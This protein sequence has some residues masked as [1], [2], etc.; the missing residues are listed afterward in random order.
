[1]FD[2][3]RSQLAIP[4]SAPSSRRALLAAS[5]GSGVAFVASALGRPSS[6]LAGSDGDVVL[7]SSVNVTSA[8]TKITTT[9]SVTTFVAENNGTGGIAISAMATELGGSGLYAEAQS[10]DGVGVFGASTDGTG[11]AAQSTNG[12]AVRGVSASSVGV[13]GLTSSSSSYAVWG[14]ATGGIGVLGQSGSSIGV[15]GTSTSWIGVAGSSGSTFAVYGEAN[16]SGAGAIGVHGTSQNGV[17]M[18]GKSRAAA[19]PGVIGWSGANSTG[20]QGIS[21]AN[22]AN[23]PTPKAKTGVFGQA[24]QD[25][26]SRGVF[27]VSTSGNGVRGESTTGGAVVG[28][29]NNTA[30]YAFLGSGRVRFNKVSGLATIA[31]GATSVTVT[32]G[33]D[34]TSESFVLLTAKTNIGT[35]SLYFTT[36]P[37][38]NRF[39]IRLSASPSVSTVV[40]WLLLG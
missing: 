9:T 11:V 22:E 16:G 17:G 34:L 35:R 24:T 10:G 13:H 6:V 26:S 20:I 14:E 15:S 27:G 36:D 18:L 37:T 30:G 40:A 23:P 5:L 3:A 28:V 2:R 33:T 31:A 29:A 21:N 25:S 32:P 19:Q 38:N 7:G 39:T 8:T 4:G 12:D 1:M